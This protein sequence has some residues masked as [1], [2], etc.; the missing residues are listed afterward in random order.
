MCERKFCNVKM[1]VATF[2]YLNYICLGNEVPIESKK[3]KNEK[4]Q[5]LE[6]L[7]YECFQPT[8][9]YKFCEKFNT[10]SKFLSIKK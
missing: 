6:K 9:V 8:L 7:R 3:K 4:I 1:Y 2:C 5:I 10:K